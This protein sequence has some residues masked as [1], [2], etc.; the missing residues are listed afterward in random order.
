MHDRRPR[1]HEKT[2]QELK[3]GAE[4]DE[5]NIVHFPERRKEASPSDEFFRTEESEFPTSE[6]FAGQPKLELLP[7][8]KILLGAAFVMAGIML[9]LLLFVISW[10][11]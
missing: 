10:P 2:F 8:E 6:P 1:R 11:P 7:R 4:D 5:C 9:M 3:G